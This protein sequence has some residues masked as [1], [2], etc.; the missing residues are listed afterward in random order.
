M[1]KQNPFNASKQSHIKKPKQRIGTAHEI[2]PATAVLLVV[3]ATEIDSAET[4]T[5]AISVATT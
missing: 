5:K 1:R 4:L 2:K 3:E